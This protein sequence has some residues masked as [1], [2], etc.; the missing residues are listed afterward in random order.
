MRVGAGLAQAGKIQKG[1]RAD[2]CKNHLHQLHV[3]LPSRPGH[4]RLLYR[5]SMD[6]LHWTK[7]VPG[8]QQFWKHIAGQVLRLFWLPPELFLKD[9][10]PWPDERLPIS[11]SNRD[12]KLC[13][14]IAS[15]FAMQHVG[16]RTLQA[17]L[18]GP[19][20]LMCM[21][22]GLAWTR[23]FHLAL[24]ACVES[25]ADVQH[26]HVFHSGG[27]CHSLTSPVPYRFAR[28]AS[29]LCCCHIA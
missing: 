2:A 19:C 22:L 5:M 14:A 11:A 26:T 24:E 29:G 6:F 25:L 23:N 17:P 13:K 27:Q 12:I 21:L 1:C 8:I 18:L 28:L 15:Y 4:T 7:F 9:M 20:G 16:Q 10:Q 3:C